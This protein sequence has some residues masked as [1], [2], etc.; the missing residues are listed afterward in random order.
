MLVLT[1]RQES[2]YQVPERWRAKNLTADYRARCARLGIPASEAVDRRRASSQS[3]DLFDAHDVIL[4]LCDLAAAGDAAATEIAVEFVLSE[5]YFFYSGFAR[6]RAA[7]RLRR[8]PLTKTQIGS[9]Q[10]G[11]IGL[12][13]K[14]HTGQEIREFVRLLKKVGLGSLKDRAEALKSSPNARVSAYA[15]SLPE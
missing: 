11:I 3:Y 5:V 10:D 9:L 15:H 14:G 7:R 2:Y 12:L 6:S 4:N 1:V 13:E 8:A